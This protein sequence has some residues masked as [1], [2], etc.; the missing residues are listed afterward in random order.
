MDVSLAFFLKPI[1]TNNV[2]AKE[3]EWTQYADRLSTKN[4][5]IITAVIN[6]LLKYQ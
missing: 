4:Q 1:E 5:Q 3:S 6:V 2:A